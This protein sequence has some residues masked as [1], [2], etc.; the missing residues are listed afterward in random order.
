MLTIPVKAILFQPG[1]NTLQVI[2]EERKVLLLL[3]AENKIIITEKDC[4][5]PV[6]HADILTLEAIVFRDQQMEVATFP[7]RESLISIPA[8]A[9]EL[10]PGGNTIWVHSAKGATILR[11]KS[12]SRIKG[13][14]PILILGTFDHSKDGN[15]FAEV[16]VA[17]D[18]KICLTAEVAVQLEAP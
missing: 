9:M 2:S 4:R 17:G 1:D 15:F 16:F 10:S 12:M 7:N 18:I 8:E 6:C 13:T 3:I 14:I 5:N 11:I